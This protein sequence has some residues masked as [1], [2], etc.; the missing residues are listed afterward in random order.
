MPWVQKREAKGGERK[1]WKK[2]KAR[3]GGKEASPE[4][5]TQEGR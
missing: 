1:A 5:T 3:K 4:R 2:F